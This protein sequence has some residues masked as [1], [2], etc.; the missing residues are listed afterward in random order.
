MTR[1]GSTGDD[2]DNDFSDAGGGS[3][4]DAGSG[5][6]GD[7]GSDTSYGGG[8][9]DESTAGSDTVSGPGAGDDAG[10]GDG[11]SDLGG[12]DDDDSSGVVGGGG[13]RRGD[14][15]DDDYRGAYYDTDYADSATGGDP[16]P[17]S[18]E[19]GGADDRT[20]DD[21]T[22][23]GV[24][25]TRPQSTGDDPSQNQGGA[26]GTDTT[27]ELDSD[28]DDDLSDGSLDGTPPADA[29][30]GTSITTIPRQGDRGELE[31]S[32]RARE[33]LTG[34]LDD[35]SVVANEAV[36]DTVEQLQGRID[37]EIPGLDASD[38][39]QY[40][41]VRDGDQLSVELSRA[42]RREAL[43]R[44]AADQFEVDPD[45][46]DVTDTGSGFEARV[47]GESVEGGTFV[48]GAPDPD[49]DYYPE[50]TGPNPSFRE[51]GPGESP[52]DASY[53]PQS[54]GDDSEI[55]PQGGDMRL[56][57]AADDGPAPI[58]GG[59]VRLA[60]VAEEQPATVTDASDETPVSGGDARLETVA[61]EQPELR[62]TE[63]TA[64]EPLNY[65]RRA[66]YRAGLDV[67]LGSTDEALGRAMTA[68][69]PVAAADALA[70]ST[71]EAIGRAAR[72]SAAGNRDRAADNL[73]GGLDDAAAETI[74]AATTLWSERPRA[75]VP[76][77][78]SDN[79]LPGL[80]GDA[81]AAGTEI[82]EDTPRVRDGSNIPLLAD[83]YADAAATGAAIGQDINED[84]ES[85]EI[86]RATT[87]R[88]TRGGNL[89]ERDEQ[90]LREA[91]A[92]FNADARGAIDDAAAVSPL[93]LQDEAVRGAL[94]A[95]GVD[96]DVETSIGTMYGDAEFDTE[97]LGEGNIER[98][99]ENA[100]RSVVT[101]PN[102]FAL[103]QAGE[104]GV[105]VASNLDDEV[106]VGDA[107][108]SAVGTSALALSRES[109]EAL[110]ERA[111][112]DPTRAAGSL[113]GEVVLGYGVGRGAGFVARRGVGRARTFGGTH[114]DLDEFTNPETVAYF[115]DPDADVGDEA[116]FPGAE[117]P[118]LHESDPAEAVRQQADEYTPAPIRE[119]F[120][121]AGVEEGVVLKKGIETE[122][123]GEGTTRVPLDTGR[124]FR[125]EEGGYESPGGFAGPELSP[126]FLGVGQRSYSLRPGFPGLGGRPTGVLARTDVEN[127]DADT[128]G[129]FNREL[130][131]QRAA[132]TTAVTKPANAANPG[133]IETVIPPGA[134]F[135]AIDS[136]T[137]GGNRFG[138]GT[139]YYTTVRGR[140]VPLRLI[141]PDDDVDTDAPNV[142][143]DAEG[144]P[145]SYY[146]RE[147]SETVDRP[148]PT[149]APSA[150]DAGES[151]VAADSD[152]DL[153]GA[154]PRES[155]TDD[156][157][158]GVRE[159]EPAGRSETAADESADDLLGVR[160]RETES[161]R[162]T[163]SGAG[164][165]DDLL[166]VRAPE[167]D[168]ESSRR[169][170]SDRD[171]G[172]LGVRSGSSESERRDRS[173]RVI[174]ASSGS[175]SGSRARR[176]RDSYLTP[177]ISSGGGSSERGGSTI[178]SW[179]STPSI[180][181]RSIGEP[182]TEGPPTEGPPTEGPPP[183]EPP[184][185]QPERPRWD[186]NPDMGTPDRYPERTTES[187]RPYS[188]GYYN[189][190]VADFA[191][192]AAPTRAPSQETLAAFEG[193][194]AFTEQLPTLRELDAAGEERAALEAAY[195]TFGVGDLTVT[196]DDGGG[197]L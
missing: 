14:D 104:T 94:E 90:R 72:A 28:L 115:N 53:R 121:A 141:A 61:G 44:Q 48:T 113:A 189:E 83:V 2:S 88:L 62:A 22:S 190:F 95:A 38:T 112:A 160:P 89:S 49:R 133:E 124:G 68:D 120:E 101:S 27:D 177:S 56:L 26:G 30:R 97:R 129:A 170:V 108:T 139:G 188:V 193:A 168:L 148:A 71:D 161:A 4:T 3:D 99:Q 152:D 154:R 166:G 138:F 126:Y 17:S 167:S 45:R 31:Q 175:G 15:S 84:I 197:L 82:G 37:R 39:S 140:R 50:E 155:G 195:E 1:R 180:T 128:M 183:V 110:V 20:V 178:D 169:S 127:P 196:T 174:G 91:S 185:E 10:G 164:S 29:D 93:T 63:A 102:P 186:W 70:G 191:L 103:A 67:L 46:V 12:G 182:P 92:Q 75:S 21:I 117:D 78:G 96:T 86:N 11:D 76:G 134:T 116:R 184:P 173:E 156:D 107:A 153:V 57:A 7:S 131:E 35:E 16:N 8:S 74:A 77:D 19:V 132:E 81:V 105:E 181:G 142:D 162:S 13:S 137:S 42:A 150:G 47:E 125:T 149:A 143:P 165:E 25:D 24:G 98:T 41:I 158:L 130:V 135:R 194:E 145:Y 163:D 159:R 187:D 87:D 33:E 122:P 85:A 146:Y 32:E 176:D 65:G 151:D 23:G 114:V 106:E 157:L 79:I 52:A 111:R 43:R 51:V 172:L 59:D 179:L 60:N 34:G 80:Y 144:Q 40:D 100:A 119:D 64:E 118:D 136:A 18:R 73:A 69:S 5:V 36:D 55:S 109:G 192:G 9:T 171:D 6:T 58:E 66:K 54:T 147:A 123:E